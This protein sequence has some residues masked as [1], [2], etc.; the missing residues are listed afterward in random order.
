MSKLQRPK[1][2]T[3]EPKDF[4]DDIKND[5]AAGYRFTPFLGSGISAQSGIIM[6]REFD[7][8]LA[9]TVCQVLDHKWDIR[10]NG[11]PARPNAKEIR[12]TTERVYELF[13][14]ACNQYNCEPIPH[15]ENSL[16]VAHVASMAYDVKVLHAW[17]KGLIPNKGRRLVLFYRAE[18]ETEVHGK[19]FDHEGKAKTPFSVSID[20]FETPNE[21]TDRLESIWNQTLP[22][23]DKYDLLTTVQSSAR[24]RKK[25]GLD[26]SE[27]EM[28]ATSEQRLS[29]QLRRPLVPQILRSRR[30]NFDELHLEK[31]RKSW[32]SDEFQSDLKESKSSTRFIRET[33]VRAL[34]H[35]SRT[36]EFLASMRRDSR[37]DLLYRE[38]IDQS[39]ID[40]FNAHITRGKRPNLIHNMIA[41]LSRT[42]RTRVVLSTNFDPLIESSFRLQGEPLHVLAVSIKGGLPAYPTVR[43]QDCLVKLHGDILETRADTS[44]DEPPSEEDKAAFFRYLMGP[45]SHQQDQPADVVPS[46]LL[47]VGYS[48]SDARCVQLIKYVLDVSPDFKVYWI[49]HSRE[50]SANV[51]EI[52]SEYC[53]KNQRKRF[54]PTRTNRPDLLLWELYQAVN[55]TLPGGGHSF[56]FSHLVPPIPETP[57]DDSDPLVGHLSDAVAL[58]K[59]ILRVSGGNED[60]DTQPKA[61]WIDSDSGVATRLSAVFHYFRDEQEITPVWLELEDFK[62]PIHMLVGIFTAIALRLGSFQLEWFSFGT[63]KLKQALD[64]IESLC[65]KYELLPRSWA[66]FLYGRNGPGGCCGWDISYWKEP[67]YKQLGEIINKL[68]EMGFRVIYMPYGA[69]RAKRN[70]GSSEKK[71]GGKVGDINRQFKK[72]LGQNNSRQ[73]KTVYNTPE[74]RKWASRVWK[75]WIP[76]GFKENEKILLNPSLVAYPDSINNPKPSDGKG[77][78]LEWIEAIPKKFYPKDEKSKPFEERVELVLKEFCLLNGKSKRNKK[79]NR[80]RSARMLWLYGITLFR[81]SRHSAALL[82]EA[83]FP[84]PFR[85]EADHDNDEIRQLFLFGVQEGDSR[86]FSHGYRNQFQGKNYHIEQKGWVNWLREQQVLLRKP[87]GYVWKYRDTRLGLQFLLEQSG[88]FT[89]WDDALKWDPDT[90]DLAPSQHREVKSLWHLRARI[91]FWIGDWYLRAYH[92]TLHHIPLIEAIYHSVQALILAPYYDPIA[93]EQERQPGADSLGTTQKRLALKA[94]CQIRRLLHVGEQT[95]RFWVPG[96]D[97]VQAFFDP[98]K[99]NNHVDMLQESIKQLKKTGKCALYR[100]LQQG[101]K[102]LNREIN[103]LQQVVSSEGFSHRPRSMP[104]LQSPPDSPTEPFKEIDEISQGIDMLDQAHPQWITE[105]IKRYFEALGVSADLEE[106]AKKPFDVDHFWKQLSREGNDTAIDGSLRNFRRTWLAAWAD[107]YSASEERLLHMI[108]GISELMYRLVRRAK[109]ERYSR[110]TAKDRTI[111]AKEKEKEANLWSS[112][113]AVGHLGLQF[114]RYLS[115]RNYRTD[116]RLR[117]KILTMYGLALG[118]LGRFTESNRRFNEAHALLVSGLRSTDGRELGKIHLRLAE[119]HLAKGRFLLEEWIQNGKPR[120]SKDHT[121][122]MVSTIDDA[123]AALERAELSMASNNHSEFWWYRLTSL[124]LKTYAFIAECK[125]MIW[126]VEVAKDMASRRLPRCLPFRRRLHYPTVLRSLLRDALI[127]G[128]GD[129]FRQL[130]ALDHFLGASRLEPDSGEGADRRINGMLIEETSGKTPL[131]LLAEDSGHQVTVVNS[132]ISELFRRGHNG[133]FSE[134]LQAYF[135]KVTGLVKEIIDKNKPK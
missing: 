117:I 67:E 134:K 124:K 34:S 10:N 59:E 17:N 72:L 90:G 71:A 84:C 32:H 8:Y 55:L 6:G 33:A 18:D 83:V 100:R 37:R 89:C 108:W 20:N 25:L 13:H 131:L 129:N 66:I 56:Q 97:I 118:Y 49:C 52:F 40:S 14:E 65:E 116:S 91:H 126:D 58:A 98:S 12:K 43:A 109:L 73:N 5:L 36:L 23:R 42:L 41:R 103:L 28:P 85:F 114:S 7:N 22:T 68:I 81:H 132:R 107:K 102:S 96:V 44:I 53:D 110:E 92:S 63:T 4:I 16:E 2:T 77:A 38:G 130:R 50:D 21:I 60:H 86:S 94:L 105:G 29:E 48:A 26:I 64:R 19:V 31:M 111:A 51:A 104:T 120:A 106:Y 75:Q 78:P 135:Q 133:E 45:R 82:S 123:W 57:S 30:L 54:I 99:G 112:V 76:D 79:L 74:Y 125:E 1:P 113:C 101:L 39:V 62:N 70:F 27:T 122:P 35:W 88:P 95:F 115:A 46:R 11:W 15:E 47:V 119:K 93:I 87:G 69:E 9:Y 121:Y 3:V 80:V 127:L 24:D 61:V 128:N